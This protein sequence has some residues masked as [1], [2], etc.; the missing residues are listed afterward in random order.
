MPARPAASRILRQMR[1]AAGRAGIPYTLSASGRYTGTDADALTLVR[2]GVPTAVVSIPNRY[3]HSPSEMVDARD[4]Q[5]C[6]DIIAAWI[7]ELDVEADF[8]R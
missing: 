1:D 8:T 6:V 5:A 2:S 3:M 7:R 4:V